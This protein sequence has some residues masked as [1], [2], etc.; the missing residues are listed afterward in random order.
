FQPDSKLEKESIENQRKRYPQL[1]R[2]LSHP[3]NEVVRN[4]ITSIANLLH[5]GTRTTPRTSDHPHFE[6]MTAYSGLE[7]L[8]AL[9]K[10]ADISEEIRD[11]AAICIGRLFR[12]KAIPDKFRTEIIGC[13]IEIVRNQDKH[14]KAQSVIVLCD[15]VQNP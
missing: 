15:L 8:Y 6:E 10:R 13:L 14:I 3:D 7:K 4:S 9:F 11:Q 5:L 1:L 12:S 2:L